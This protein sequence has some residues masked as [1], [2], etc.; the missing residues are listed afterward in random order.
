MSFIIGTIIA[1]VFLDGIARF[2]LIAVVALVEIA[3]IGVWLKWRK[4]RSI[5]GA[6]SFAG[7]P[8][9]VVSDCDPD[10]QVRVKGQIWKAHCAE[11]AATGDKVE[12]TRIDG[13]RLEVARR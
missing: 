12:V 3:E 7:A 10:G 2:G 1:V 4:I 8:G 11:G 9:V 5:T 13:L 6:E